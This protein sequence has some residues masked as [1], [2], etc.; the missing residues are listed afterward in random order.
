MEIACPACQ[1]RFNLKTDRMPRTAFKVVCGKCRH[2]F[3]V[4]PPAEASAPAAAAPIAPPPS[5]VAPPSPAVPAAADGT[6]A[7]P[8]VEEFQ[9]GLKLALVCDSDPER[10]VMIV[11]ALRELGYKAHMAPGPREALSW[12]YQNRY[13]VLLLHEEF[14]GGSP[15]RNEVL[16]GLAAMQMATRRHMCVGL[17]GR[18]LRTMDNMTAFHKSVNFVVNE[19]DCPRLKSIIRTAVAD[20][21]Q[22]YRVFRE[23]LKQ[24]G[25]A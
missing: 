11:A 6:L 3:M 17:C 12:V 4:E 14:A 9:E 23:T 22:F 25:K 15:E 5:P 21:D 7:G 8:P 24:V 2:Q 18:G 1:S 19:R 20:N 10:Q 13:E 16:S